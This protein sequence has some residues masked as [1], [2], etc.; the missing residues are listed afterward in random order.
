[1]I[2]TRFDTHFNPVLSSNSTFRQIS[3]VLDPIKY[4]SSVPESNTTFSQTTKIFLSGVFFDFQVG[5]YVYQGPS[6]GEATFIGRVVHW[7][8]INSELELTEI[9]G[10]PT[11][12][13]IT[14][15]QSFTSGFVNSIEYPDLEP[16]SG[17]ILFINNMTAVE[18]YPEQSEEFKIILEF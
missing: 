1:M 2:S 17:T 12:A 14:G 7:D 5:E 18:R 13:S 3:L 11:S 6:T 16:F 8:P 15:N 9:D 10:E 4:G